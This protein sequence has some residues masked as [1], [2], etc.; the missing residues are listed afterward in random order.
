V[1]SRVVHAAAILVLLAAVSRYYDSATGFTALIGFGEKQAA[2]VV[3]AVKD[4]PR[5]IARGSNGY[6]GQFYVQMAVDPLLRDPATDR[7]MD[8]APLRAR[9]ILL[10]WT[11]YALGFGRPAW[12]LQV[13][14]LQNVIAW[15][16]LSVV[17]RRWFPLTS[18]RGLCLWLL[19]LFSTG[20]MW[21]VRFALLDGPSLLL[22]SLAVA[23]LEGGR[24]WIAATVCGV[25]GL[26]RETNV[27]SVFGLIDRREWS[28]GVRPIARQIASIVVAL[29]PLALWSDY[30]RSIYRSLSFTSG[31]TL[32]RPF[33]GLLWRAG[34]GLNLEK[35]S[36]GQ[37]AIVIL[38]VVAFATQVGFLLARPGWRDPWWRIGVAYAALLAFLGQ[39]LWTATP[40]SVVRV[41]LP[42]LL[43][44]NIGLLG[45]RRQA[46]FWV[47][48]L[49]GNATIVL[50]PLIQ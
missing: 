8:E 32:T 24:R 22:L 21:S 49:L 48:A 44:F 4:L 10:S 6:D 47:L 16:A 40:P 15:I 50:Q 19:T 26:A 46:A 39:P 33:A 25:A 12:I 38:L 20:L 23:A 18:A 36:V 29:L 43:A 30:I 27:L 9:R 37:A 14:A 5:E 35:S 34:V 28:G 42:L 13:F 11:A 7:A 41:E 3:P 17:L 1:R 45:V 2:S 31:E